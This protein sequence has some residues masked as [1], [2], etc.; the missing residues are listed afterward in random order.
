MQIISHIGVIIATFLVMQVTADAPTFWKFAEAVFNGSLVFVALYFLW[1]QRKM[2]LKLNE[3]APTVMDIA[4]QFDPKQGDSLRE[5]VDGVKSD[6]RGIRA[7]THL[8]LNH[9]PTPIFLLDEK[10]NCLFVNEAW[11]QIAG[12]PL[13]TAKDS[14]WHQ[15]IHDDD[16]KSVIEAID[17]AISRE[18]NFFR[19][20]RIV[21]M[22]AKKIYS[23][24]AKADVTPIRKGDKPS[25]K[26][27]VKYVGEM[28]ILK[29]EDFE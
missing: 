15:V 4:Q 17:E 21:N 24:R 29:V 3:I 25:V 19:S 27:S 8:L 14:G 9:N 10:G 16:R 26:P 23:V 5:T 22:T 20:F 2:L 28:V 13:S 6:I 7:K 11:C 12:I 18:R 1:K